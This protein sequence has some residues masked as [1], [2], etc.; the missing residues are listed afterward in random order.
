MCD[1]REAESLFSSLVYQ[2]IKNGPKSEG[3]LGIFSSFSHILS[4]PQ[5]VTYH[6][7]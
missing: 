6:H 3:V 1:I 2:I 5:S 7:F 4:R